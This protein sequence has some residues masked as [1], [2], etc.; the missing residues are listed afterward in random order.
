VISKIVKFR[1]KGNLARASKREEEREDLSYVVTGTHWRIPTAS[2]QS[3]LAD[4][5]A[6][7][8]LY[9]LPLKQRRYVAKG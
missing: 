2:V 4:D 8:R 7:V 5:G 9:A 3:P 6:R 1:V